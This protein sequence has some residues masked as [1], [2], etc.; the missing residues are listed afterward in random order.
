MDRGTI[1]RVWTPLI[2]GTCAV[3][4]VFIN[5]PGPH[6]TARWLGLALASIGLAGVILAR[7]TLGQ[8]FSLAP[9]ARALVTTG[10]YSKIRNPIY[11]SGEIVLIGMALMLWQRS[12]LFFLLIVIPIQVLRA[13]KE[14][15]VLE[16]KFGEE[17][18]AY[19]RGT[20]F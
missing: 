8:S 15:R 11:V 10:I 14:A 16:E 4:V 20:W 9:K 19:R 17:Y 2:M 1:W 7:L 5:G 6:G 12:L 18:R 3:I 13:R